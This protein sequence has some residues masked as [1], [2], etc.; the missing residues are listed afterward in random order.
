MILWTTSHQHIDTERQPTLSSQDTFA[1]GAYSHLLVRIHEPR[2]WT[3]QIPFLTP[4]FTLMMWITGFASKAYNMISTAHAWILPRRASSLGRRVHTP[5]E[6]K[7]QE[8]FSCFSPVCCMCR[9][10]CVTSSSAASRCFSD[11]HSHSHPHSHSHSPLAFSSSVVFQYCCNFW[12]LQ[13]EN[14]RAMH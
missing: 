6:F 10:D 8:H 12:V 13:N 7:V 2:R 3:F 1:L 5:A 4:S 14:G 11:F 9:S